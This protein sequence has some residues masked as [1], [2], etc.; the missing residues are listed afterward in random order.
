MR[1]LL[2]Q[3][4]AECENG[5]GSTPAYLAFAAGFAEVATLLIK[6]GCDVNI[7]N[8]GGKTFLHLAAERGCV[9]D[10]V[11]LIGYGAD[12]G[13]K[14]ALRNTPLHSACSHGA[15]AV[16][17]L[18]LETKAATS[19]APGKDAN[20]P[21]HVAAQNPSGANGRAEIVELLLESGASPKALN[22]ESCRPVDMVQGTHVDDAEIRD[23]LLVSASGL[24]NTP[25]HLT[26]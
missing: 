1:L 5:D 15:W 24:G 19:N 10:T 16:G 3:S 7:A 25:P 14:D 11:W 2:A 23:I 13:A 17:Q 21:L 9:A 20:T 18:L 22:K 12:A 6:E 4:D 8:Q 26:P